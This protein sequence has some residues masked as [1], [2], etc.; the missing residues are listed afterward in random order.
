[1]NKKLVENK[2]NLRKCDLDYLCELQNSYRQMTNQFKNYLEFYKENEI[3][4]LTLSNDKANYVETFLRV[5]NYTSDYLKNIK[6]TIFLECNKLIDV[7]Y[8]YFIVEYDFR[9]SNLK[10]DKKRSFYDIPTDYNSKLNWFLN[11][12]DINLILE[13]I[14]KEVG[15]LDFQKANQDIAKEDVLSRGIFKIQSNKL[16]LNEYL[17]FNN[18]DFNPYEIANTTYSK[19][20]VALK[21]LF[22]LMSLYEIDSTKCSYLDE[23]YSTILS[24]LN[25]TGKEFRVDGNW[26]ESF[27]IFRTGKVQITFDNKVSATFFAEQHLNYSKNKKA[28]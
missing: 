19:N 7:V 11:E 27:K 22:K 9:L 25:P 4:I 21:Q 5:S 6:N 14:A 1:M 28:V 8:H 2:F 26:I 3:P 20:R 17:Y 18:C 16:I 13:V 15:Y 10:R 24:M 12:L 23:I